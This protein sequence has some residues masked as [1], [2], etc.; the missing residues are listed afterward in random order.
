MFDNITTWN[1]KNNNRPY[2]VADT[3]PCIPADFT[4]GATNMEM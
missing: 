1:Y 3:I 4:S 2:S